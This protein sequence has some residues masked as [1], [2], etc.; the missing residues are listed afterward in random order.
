[1]TN[2]HLD[3]AKVMDCY[4]G[5]PQVLIKTLR[6][7]HSTLPTEWQLF[8][9]CC[10]TSDF[11]QASVVSHRMAGTLSMVGAT[12]FADLMRRISH[13][14]KENRAVPTELLAR[15]ITYY[16]A[17]LVEIDSFVARFPL[18]ASPK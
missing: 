15:A 13:V 5:S 3:L 8:L 11:N 6:R 2:K 10:D 9:T 16:D 12:E 4:G 7:I 17:V 18:E 14:T 1:M